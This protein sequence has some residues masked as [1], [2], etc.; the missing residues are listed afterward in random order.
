[1]AAG[2]EEEETWSGAGAGSEGRSLG[3]SSCWEGTGS[4]V[5]CLPPWP[6]SHVVIPSGFRI[7]NTQRHLK[8][9]M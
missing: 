2:E 3:N 5:S 6:Y 1:M 8:Y 4:E 9:D 7:S